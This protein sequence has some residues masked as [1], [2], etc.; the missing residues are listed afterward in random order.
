MP[1]SPSVRGQRGPV[2]LAGEELPLTA[3]RPS[4]LVARGP[5]ICLDEAGWASA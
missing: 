4:R 2:L 5:A 3:L 1:R